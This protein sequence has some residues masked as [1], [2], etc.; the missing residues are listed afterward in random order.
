MPEVREPRATKLPIRYSIHL[1]GTVYGSEDVLITHYTV[2]FVRH[3]CL[4]WHF[5]VVRLG[6]CADCFQRCRHSNSVGRC[7]D[8]DGYEI[9]GHTS[10]S[11]GVECW[12]FS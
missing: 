3:I 1:L 12:I 8:I 10:C 7:D 2:R 9:I 5:T 4:C 11:H 6:S